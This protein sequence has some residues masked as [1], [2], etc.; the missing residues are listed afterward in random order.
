[1]LIVF[2]VAAADCDQSAAPKPD[3]PA[4]PAPL[5][6][7]SNVQTLVYSPDGGYDLGRAGP[8]GA[9]SRV[10]MDNGTDATITI[11]LSHGRT[12]EV[13]SR[14][15]VVV[16]FSTR[17]VRFV[18]TRADGTL[19]DDVTI[20]GA[21]GATW[22][23]DPLGAW[24]YVV[25]S[26]RYNRIGA[27]LVGAFGGGTG[28]HSLRLVGP[29]LFHVVCDSLFAPLPREVRTAARAEKRTAGD[30]VE[31]LERQ[32]VE[33]ATPGPTLGRTLQTT[34]MG[35]RDVRV[36]T[37]KSEVSIYDRDQWGQ[38]GGT[39]AAGLAP[40]GNVVHVR[41]PWPAVAGQLFVDDT[42]IAR[43]AASEKIDLAIPSG[44][45]V[46]SARAASGASLGSPMDAD[47]NPVTAS[48]VGY[49]WKPAAKPPTAH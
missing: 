31:A 35:G 40:Q 19:L 4:A 11:D 29:V 26:V 32:S 17:S 28:E 25:T 48:V 5:S 38:P 13:P 21:P 45:H 33:H 6:T 41:V 36:V 9:V 44:H 10:V 43:V 3:P 8:A 30:D 15:N 47:F 2:A 39:M 14:K 42:S 27:S 24:D 1:M 16:R 46:L 20:D 22:F 34:R 18:A 7:T 49:E 12:F 23:Y 37:W